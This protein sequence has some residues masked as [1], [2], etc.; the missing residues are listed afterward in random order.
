ML[1]LLPHLCGLLVPY[2]AAGRARVYQFSTGVS[3]L[4]LA[5]LQQGGLETTLGTDARCVFEH[6]LSTPRL[7][8]LLILTDGYTGGPGDDQRLALAERRIAVHVVLPADS[9][10]ERDLAPVATSITVLPPLLKRS[11]R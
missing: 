1:H 5:A 8:R 10:Y 11:P 6:A 9:A 2:V 3:L 4:T 7:R